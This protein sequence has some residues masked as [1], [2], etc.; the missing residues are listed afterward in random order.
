VIK[1]SDVAGQCWQR[2]DAGNRHVLSPINVAVAVPVVRGVVDVPAVIASLATAVLRGARYVRDKK[3][4]MR[5]WHGV[6]FFKVNATSGEPAWG[7]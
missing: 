6:W 4:E 5:Q 2:L 7:W 1:H 3:G